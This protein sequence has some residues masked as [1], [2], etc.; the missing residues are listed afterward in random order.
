MKFEKVS[1]EQYKSLFE[2]DDR[3]LTEEEAASVRE[4]YDALIFPSRATPGSAG[5]DF[6]MP[7]D[8]CFNPDEHESVLIPTGFRVYMEPGECLLILPRSGLG[9]K[10][11][12]R[13]MNTVGLIDSDYYYADNEGHILVNFTADKPF[14]L[15]AGDAFVQGVF[16]TYETTTFDRPRGHVRRG[17]FG[18][19]D[20]KE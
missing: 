11:G 2:T 10:V 5:Y 9:T 3:K 6:F 8:M 18:S 13:L 14:N 12:F 7:F 19:T 20:K 15:R 17:G 16:M 1:F 4:S